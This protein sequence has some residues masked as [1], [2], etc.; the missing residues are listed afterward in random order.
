[1]TNPTLY[2]PLITIFVFLSYLGS[3]PFWLKAGSAYKDY[4]TEKDQIKAAEENQLLG[5]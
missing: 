4:M 1:L 2:G 5:A 3:V